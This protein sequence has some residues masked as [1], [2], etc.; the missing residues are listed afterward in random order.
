ML[1]VDPDGTADPQLPPQGEKH[2]LQTSPACSCGSNTTG[3]S[4]AGRRLGQDPG[5]DRSAEDEDIRR[6]T[7]LSFPAGP[8]PATPALTL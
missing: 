8:C 6:A 3:D 1:P 2:S 7:C 5:E 4:G